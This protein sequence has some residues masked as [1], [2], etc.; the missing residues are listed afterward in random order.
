MAQA[1]RSIRI[2][3]EE[4]H[5]SAAP[6]LRARR[7]AS[8]S[9]VLWKRQAL[10]L[11]GV[12]CVVMLFITYISGFARL[13]QL[14]Y[15]KMALQQEV[16]Q[17]ERQSAQL[18]LE[19]DR[20]AAQPRVINMAQARGLEVPTPDRI[21]YI[22]ARELPPSVMATT[23]Q[24]PAPRQSWIAR[25]GGRLVAAVGGA[26]QRLSRGPGEPAYARE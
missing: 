4:L 11:A 10:V 9:P 18:N 2:T 17:L 8:A 24:A 7:R 1:A 15:R 20:L 12:A 14:E 16:E 23:P 19:I 25:S 21:D 5:E 22:P 13:A 6:S 3:S 26:F